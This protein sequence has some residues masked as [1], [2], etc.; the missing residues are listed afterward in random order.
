MGHLRS[1]PFP[2]IPNETYVPVKWDYS[3]LNEKIMTL[4]ENYAMQQ[5]FYVE[6]MRQA[7]ANGYAAQNLV[8]D[9]YN[10]I[11]NLEGYGTI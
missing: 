9:T 2:Y 1:N 11:S 5:E 7:Y 10:W 8:I 4:L 3:D 6:N